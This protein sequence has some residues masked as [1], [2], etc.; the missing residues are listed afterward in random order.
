VKVHGIYN[1][2]EDCDIQ[3]FGNGIQVSVGSNYNEIKNCN[4]LNNENG[5]DIRASSDQNVVT[6]CNIYYNLQSIKIWQS[7][8][9]NLVYLN[10]FWKNDVV[11]IDEANNTWD[12]GQEGNYWDRYKGR[13]SNSDGIG[14]TPYTISAGNVDNFPLFSMILP[15]IIIH[16]TNVRLTTSKSDST[17][18]FSWNPSIYSKGIK[19]YHVKIDNSKD[20]FIGDTTSWTSSDTLVDGVHMFYVKGLGFDNANSNYSILSFSIDS[21]IIDTDRDSWSDIEEVEY[22]TDPNNSNNYP[23]DTDTDHMPDSI[24]SDDDD[25]GYS[26]EME[27]S[28]ATSTVN[29]FVYPLD[30]DFDGIPNEDS[31]DGK[32]TGDEDDDGDG[33]ADTTENSLGSNPI[34][35]EDVILVY[36]SGKSYYLVDISGNKIFDFLY[37]PTSGATNGIEKYGVDYRI[38]VDGDDSYDHIFRTSNGTVSTYNEQITI[39][40]V[41]WLLIVLIILFAALYFLPR[42]LKER[43]IKLKLSRKPEKT[44]KTSIMEKTLKVPLGEKKDTVMMIDQTK[45]LLQHIHQDV[46]A[47]ME[48]LRDLEQQFTTIPT[49]DKFTVE[50]HKEDEP[51][52]EKLP[53]EEPTKEEIQEKEITSETKDISE[54]EAKVDKILSA[55]D[56]KDK[57]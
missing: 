5:I 24:D 38:D 13:D 10:N 2:V 39:P 26:D 50:E 30:T 41:I 42:H 32:Y 36:V 43:F 56:D 4:I 23:L 17:P 40:T 3:N 16:P 6:G 52:I 57:N 12:N 1:I 20:I 53:K 31:P 45:A 11:A 22:G 7:S 14:D 29:L 9:G 48:Q 49:K 54:L 8:N 28:Y 47:Y 21:S 15:D 19:G 51:P 35:G 34:N 27:S 37:V 55:L 18:S 46:E 44:F 25:D 33:L